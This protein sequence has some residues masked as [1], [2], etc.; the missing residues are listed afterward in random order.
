MPFSWTD[1]AER[2]AHSKS[3]RPRSIRFAQF[4]IRDLTLEK[5]RDPGNLQARAAADI[6]KKHAPD[7]LSI[8]E[9]EA[10]PSAPLIFIENFLE[11]GEDP[12]GYPFFYAGQSNSGVK[13]GFSYPYDYRGYGRFA[14]QYGIACLSRFKIRYEG[15]RNLKDTPWRSI[16][17]SY[18]EGIACPEDFPLWSNCFLDIPLEIAEGLVIHAILIHPTVPLRDYTNIRRNR[19]RLSSLRPILKDWRGLLWLWGI[20]MPTRTR[21]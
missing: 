10:D 3:I 21:A 15:I 16:A 12:A 4:N 7:I 5:L 14:G 18:C 17:M 19:T 1:M 6:I 13:T 11:K 8:N 20:S 9:M 2:P